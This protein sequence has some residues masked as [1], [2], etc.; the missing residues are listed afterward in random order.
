M[1]LA[2]LVMTG[3]LKSKYMAKVGDGINAVVALVDAINERSRESSL[4]CCR[5]NKN[6]KS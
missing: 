5:T 6:I 1:V 2:V 4:C 3:S